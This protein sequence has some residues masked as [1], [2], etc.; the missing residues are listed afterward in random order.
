LLSSLPLGNSN[1]KLIEPADEKQTQQFI[2]QGIQQLST[3]KH[4]RDRT[5]KS[6]RFHIGKSSRN[7]TSKHSRDRTSKK[8]VNIPGN[9]SET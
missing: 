1:T 9:V 8:S 3:S 6:S 2:Q 5:S 7:R 4:S